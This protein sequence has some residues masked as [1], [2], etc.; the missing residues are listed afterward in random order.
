MDSADLQVVAFINR[1]ILNLF[2][3]TTFI[4]PVR[5]SIDLSKCV[6]LDV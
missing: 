3:Y 1:F 2:N 5:G 4:E 6:L